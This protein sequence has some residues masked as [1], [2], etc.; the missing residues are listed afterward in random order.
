MK[1]KTKDIQL[2]VDEFHNKSH[3]Q[4][5]AEFLKIKK[6]AL[7]NVSVF[8]KSVDARRKNNV[9]YVVSFVF[10]T[11]LNLDKNKNISQMPVQT[12]FFDN[13]VQ[14]QSD[15]KVLV[16]GSGSAGLFCALYLAKSGLKPILIEQGKAVE[17]RQT[18]IDKLWL[19]GVLNCDSN[20]QFG[21]GGAGTFSDGKLTTSAHNQYVYSVFSQFVKYGAPSEILT[22]AM[23]HVG[24]DNLKIVVTNIANDIQKLGGTVLFD[25]KLVDFKNQNG[26]NIA[27]LQN[28][29]QLKQVETDYII[30]AVG[31]SARDTFKVLYDNGMNISQK[32]FSVGVRIE[33]DREIINCARYGKNYDKRLPTATYKLATHLPN[34]RSVYTFCMCPGGQVVLSCSEKDTIVTNGMSFFARDERNSNSALLVNVLPSDFGSYHPLAGVEFQRKI[35][36]SAY[37]LTGSYSAPCQRVEDFLQ[38]KKSTDYGNLKPSIRPAPT[39]SNLADCLPDFVFKSL[40]QALPQFAKSIEGFDKNAIL[41]G[42]ETRSSSPIKLNRD[43][44]FATNLPNI[45]VCGEG[46]GYAGGIVTAAV[47]GLKCAIKLTE[48]I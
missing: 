24:T 42:V 23:P 46:S 38:G 5:V 15:K 43:E 26:K 16:V 4:I 34:G 20:V 1:Y 35:E 47:D 32:P 2:T 17:Q 6:D 9:H 31:H 21:L 11:K 39:P 36:R 29:G 7:S 19:D 27:V 8:K 14:K 10:E 41:T 25:T 33:H 37:Q 12:D 44:N 45:L 13:I 22:E 3:Q 18:D 48:S 28:N 30:L 40:Q